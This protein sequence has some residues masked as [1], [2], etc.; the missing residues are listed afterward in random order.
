[1]ILGIYSCS[2]ESSPG[3]VA[4]KFLIAMNDRDYV[5]AGKYS[6][7]ET[8]KLLKQLEKIEKLNNDLPEANK[9]KIIIISED[10][11]GKTATVF[12][13]QE[14]DELEQKIS[15]QKVEDADENGK[16]VS[17]WKVALRKEELPINNGKSVAP[18][19]EKLPS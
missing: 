12:F 11:Q 1:M 16:T 10:I 18:L 14:G 9:G 4:E 13:K 7:K 6:T 15:L 3:P 8:V 17:A 2:K 19:P 5:E